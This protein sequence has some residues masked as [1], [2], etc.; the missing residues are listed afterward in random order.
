MNPVTHPQAVDT[1]AQ[2]H[3]KIG[4]SEVEMATSTADSAEGVELRLAD[5]F[6]RVDKSCKKPAAKFFDCFSEKANQPPEGVSVVSVLSL[7]LRVRMISSLYDGGATAEGR[8]TSN[9][10]AVTCQALCSLSL[11]LYT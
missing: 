8:V 5:H 10:I 1:T 3:R 6:P 4:D 9:T 2:R 7:S 11:V